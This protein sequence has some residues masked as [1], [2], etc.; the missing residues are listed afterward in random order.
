MNCTLDYGNHE[1]LLYLYVD[2]V[3]N[4]LSTEEFETALNNLQSN[5]PQ[6]SV[7]LSNL[8]AFYK[9]VHAPCRSKY[10]MMRTTQTLNFIVILDTG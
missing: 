3:E 2:V 7:I 1:L 10:I 6:S 4:V 9:K 5:C 8:V